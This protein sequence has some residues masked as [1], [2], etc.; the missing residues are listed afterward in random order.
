[1][2]KSRNAYSAAAA[3]RARM[4][5]RMRVEFVLI[6]YRL[7]GVHKSK[8][9]LKSLAFIPTRTIGRTNFPPYRSLV[10][11]SHCHDES[12]EFSILYV[13]GTSYSLH[14]A[15]PHV[16]ICSGWSGQTWLLYIEERSQAGVWSPCA[17]SCTCI[18]I[19]STEQLPNSSHCQAGQR[20]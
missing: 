12:L 15:G 17:R 18:G 5:A 3:V 7:H 6:S 11:T 13:G 8:R 14:R 16:T 4:H 9:R 20:F 1:M 19:T 2:Q 10:V